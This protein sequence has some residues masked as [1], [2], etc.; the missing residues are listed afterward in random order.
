MKKSHPTLKPARMAN[1]LLSLRRKRGIA[2]QQYP[3]VSDKDNDFGK[4]GKDEK[5]STASEI[6]EEIGGGHP[7]GKP[8]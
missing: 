8:K 2:Y 3:I 6:S 1:P 4:P 7:D 5:R